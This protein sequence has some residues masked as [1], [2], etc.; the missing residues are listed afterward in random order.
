MSY[1]AAKKNLQNTLAKAF[2]SNLSFLYDYDRELY[3]K[4]DEL[5]NM[6][7][8]GTYKEKYQ[9]EF[10]EEQGEFDIYDLRNKKYL[11]NK[12]PKQWNDKIVNSFN[13]DEK[14]SILTLEKEFYSGKILEIDKKLKYELFNID[15]GNAFTINDISKFVNILN[16][17]QNN[18]KRLKELKKTIFLGTLLGRHISRIVTKHESD[19]YLIV[20]KNL[21]I[22]R[23]SL[24]VLDLTLL[25][26]N[27]GVIFSVMEDEFEYEKKVVKFLQ[28]NA[29]DNYL[30][31]LSTTDINIQS[32]LDSTLS[33]V[34]NTKP[35]AFDYNRIL[36]NFVRNISDK[37][38]AKYDFL[39]LNLVKEKFNILENKPVL[40][41]AAGPSLDDNIEWVKKNQDKFF[42]ATIGSAAKKLLD[43]EIKIDMIFTLDPQLAV[44]IVKQFPDEIMPKLEDTIIIASAI[45]HDKL[46]AKFNKKNLFIYEVFKNFIDD[47]LVLDVSSV[48]ELG[49]AMLVNMNVKEIYLIGLDLALHKITGETHAQATSEIK[50]YSKKHVKVSDKVVYGL[51]TGNFEVKGNFDKKVKTTALF[52]SSIFHI[53]QILSNK[54]ESL[55]IYN[56][57]EHGAYFNNTIPKNV[58]SIKLT[59]ILQKD[60]LREDINKKLREYSINSLCKKEKES[61]QKEIEYIKNILKTDL[62]ILKDYN[63]NCYKEFFLLVK[64]ILIKITS[65]R[66]KDNSLTILINNH[67]QI[68]FNYL[69]YIFNDAKLKK[70]LN[71]VQKIKKVYFEHLEELLYDY[72]IY[73]EKIIK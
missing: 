8:D 63:F 31:K 46:L 5:S 15:H 12:K 14:G 23:L 66:Q 47:N 11:Y 32:Y 60:K 25:A 41:L 3:L 34:L 1:E 37:L 53:N 45:T 73:I 69:N 61:L 67:A 9:L 65:F 62:V 71:K 4:V 58:E 39:R 42:I 6:I 21:E 17:K 49:L 33:A 59:N 64:E 22:F 13:M 57:S 7:N 55:K 44:M 18:K 50:N 29:L 24:F 26:K 56:L 2:L 30:I 48:G 38:V 72:I 54:D 35:S 10:L 27:S 52:S 19:L 36:Y 43:N 70:E 68:M 20:E 40:Y 51:R 28:I 16:E